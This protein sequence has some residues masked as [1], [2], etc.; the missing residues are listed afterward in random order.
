MLPPNAA[1]EWLAPLI[2]I[3][4]PRAQISVRISA[5]VAKVSRFTLCIQVDSGMLTSD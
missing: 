1:V 2:R 5:V 4:I 3:P